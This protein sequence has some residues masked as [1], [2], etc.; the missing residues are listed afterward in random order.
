MIARGTPTT[1]PV[2]AAGEATLTAY[3]RMGATLQL[4]GYA[5][6]TDGARVAFYLGQVL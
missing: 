3:I 4:A 5:E 1:S 6:P 2:N